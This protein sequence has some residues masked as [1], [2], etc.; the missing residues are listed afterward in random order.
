MK[1]LL[2]LLMLLLGA[3][4]LLASC[5]KGPPEVP[6][7]T[8]ARET[9]KALPATRPVLPP[10]EPTAETTGPPTTTMEATGEPMTDDNTPRMEVATPAEIRAEER[11]VG[12]LLSSLDTGKI[13]K[14]V[15]EQTR[16]TAA[17][18][19]RFTYEST[20]KEAIAA[21]VDVFDAMELS[22]AQFEFLSGG[23]LAVFAYADG[24][25]AELGCIEG[26]YLTNG[27]L[28]TMCRIDNYDALYGDIKSAAALVSGDVII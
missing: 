23:N 27:R 16:P 5:K 17:G 25:K 18:A 7:T 24:K 9:T 22:G 21:W 26:S 6:A 2:P 4:L 10:E 15:L 14:I 1:K 19:Q 3:T 28:K 11:R 20:S 12:S 8:K 13:D